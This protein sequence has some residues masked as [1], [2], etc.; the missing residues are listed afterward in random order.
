[1]VARGE[2]VTV[3]ERGKPIA[4]ITRVA[5]VDAD[6][7][8]LAAQGLVRLPLQPLPTDFWK[9]PRARSSAPVSEALLEDREDRF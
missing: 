9:R 4:Q 2:T 5:T 7:E 1:L 8:Q 3:L 6:L